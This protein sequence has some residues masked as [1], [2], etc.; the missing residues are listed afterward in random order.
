MF[1]FLLAAFSSGVTFDWTISLGNL[2]SAVTFLFLAV[3]AWRDLTWR[4]RNLET[5]RKEHMID[6]A[7]RD[8][9]LRKLDKVCD[10]LEFI[11]KRVA[12]YDHD[13]AD[14]K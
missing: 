3:L 5:W 2:L 12:K 4:V 1:L 11:V 7:A 8:Q 6:S 10:Q 13:E 9:L 14:K